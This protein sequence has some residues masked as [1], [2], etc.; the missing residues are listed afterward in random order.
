M[1][2]GMTR[3]Q[4]ELVE[5]SFGRIGPVTTALGM[6]FY[7]R[8]F[9]LDPSTRPLFGDA[10]EKQALKLMQILS[11]AVAN[12]HAPD[13]LLPVV[14]DLGRRHAGYGVEERHYETMRL[15]L[16]Q[17]LEASLG[18]EWNERTKAAWNAAYATIAGEMLKGARSA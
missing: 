6:A 9:A 11:Y 17:T 1:K 10:M 3:D 7:D 2:S 13:T 5:T 18:P 4:I 15:A 14:S 12:L 8:L 16:M